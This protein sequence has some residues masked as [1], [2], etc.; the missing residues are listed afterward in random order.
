MKVMRFGDAP[1]GALVRARRTVNAVEPATQWGIKARTTNPDTGQEQ[2]AV[3]WIDPNGV[4]H[5][6]FD[7]DFSD[8]LFVVSSSLH[9]VVN[10]HESE[11]EHSVFAC[12]DQA[13]FGLLLSD[14]PFFLGQS[15][16][17]QGTIF[18]SHICSLEGEV[19][20]IDYLQ[21]SYCVRFADWGIEPSESPLL[22]DNYFGRWTTTILAGCH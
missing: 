20:P 3:F 22:S 17:R 8:D 1:I 5:P 11:M 19:T 12:N 21:P 9:L 14:A 4:G 6:G 15:F 13:R 16:N 7:I 10:L 2:I 18:R